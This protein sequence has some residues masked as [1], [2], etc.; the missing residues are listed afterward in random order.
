MDEHAKDDGKG[1]PDLEEFVMVR[2]S[3]TNGAVTVESNCKFLPDQL[4]LLEFGLMFVK[5]QWVVAR[6]A[7]AG[8]RIVPSALLPPRRM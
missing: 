4:G 6:A 5:Q 8:P 7:Q 3:R 2:I 1:A